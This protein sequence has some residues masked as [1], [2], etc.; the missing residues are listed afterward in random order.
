[1]LGAASFVMIVSGGALAVAATKVPAHAV[2]LERCG[3][4]LLTLGLALLGGALRFYL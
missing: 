3:G 2:L 4:T 1:M